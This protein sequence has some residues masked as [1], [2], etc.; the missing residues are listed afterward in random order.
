MFAEFGMEL[1]VQPNSSLSRL[2]GVM[3]AQVGGVGEKP[4]D[5][6]PERK[7]QNPSQ[8]WF[9]QLEK[10]TT[11]IEEEDYDGAKEMLDRQ[12]EPTSRWSD[13]ELSIFHLRY[14]DI[15]QIQEDYDLVLEQ[16]KKILEYRESIQYFVEERT[17]HMIS[18]IY[19]SENYED[20]ETS[21]EYLQR[22]LDLTND[23]DE[24][25]SDYAFI[26]NVYNNLEDYYKTEEWWTRAIAKSEEEGIAVPDH[27]WVQLWQTYTQLSDELMD[28]PAERIIYLQKALDLSEFLISKFI[29]EKEH[30]RGQSPDSSKIDGGSGSSDPEYIPFFKPEPDYPTDALKQGIE[31]YVILQFDVNE[32]GKVENPVVLESKPTDIFDSSAIRAASKFKFNPKILNG[33]PVR[34]IDVKNR[35]TYKIGEDSDDSDPE[36]IPIFKP[37]PDYPTDALKLGIEGYVIVQFDVTEEGKVENPVVL[38]SKPDDI[39]DSSAIRAASKFKFK[40]KI[41]NDQAVR[42]SGVKNRIMYRIEEEQ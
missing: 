16:A 7:L 42:V 31:G 39:F 34:V 19:A 33:K 10:I 13:F 27:W 8:E 5:P 26:A 32:E 14:M 21:L 29:E 37:E 3:S 30:W 24:K 25:A 22:W 11:A 35:I 2:V 9:L 18:R 41:V 1:A 40:P 36:Y 4:E 6:R 28:N 38:E 15:G 20:Y 17:L 23:W 12:L